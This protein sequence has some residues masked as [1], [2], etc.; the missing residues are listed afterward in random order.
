M[1]LRTK[2]ISYL[3]CFQKQI[4]VVFEQNC[5]KS[6]RFWFKILSE[7]HETPLFLAFLWGGGLFKEALNSFFISM[8]IDTKYPSYTDE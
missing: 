8:L 5:K 6:C 2:T 1:C 3:V 7:Q 4:R